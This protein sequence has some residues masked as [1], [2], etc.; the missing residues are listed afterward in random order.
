MANPLSDEL[1]DCEGALEFG[2]IIGPDIFRNC[3]L[4]WESTHRKICF[5]QTE[6]QLFIELKLL[7]AGC[8]ECLC[9]MRN[10]GHT[11][12][13]KTYRKIYQQYLALEEM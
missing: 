13:Y 10:A 7:C 3:G 8:G 4:A 6:Q 1:L 11:Q 5:K 2:T 9:L 12:Q